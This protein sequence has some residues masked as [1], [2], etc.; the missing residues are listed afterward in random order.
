MTEGSPTAQTVLL[1]DELR[2]LRK[3]TGLTQAKV[4]KKIGTAAT[5]INKIECA[6]R[7]APE[8]LLRLML[9]LYGIKSEQQIEEYVYRAKQTRNPGWWAE[10][11]GAVPHWFERY[12]G[13]EAAAV[14]KQTYEPEHVP[15]LLQTRRYTEAIVVAMNSA[16]PSDSA[17]SLAEVR[18]TRQKRLTDPNPLALFAILN[19][20]VIHRHVGGPAVMAEQLAYLR[21]AAELPNV[22]VRILPYTAGAHPAMGRQFTMLQFNDSSIN[23]VYIEH[24]DGALYVDRPDD[25]RRYEATFRKLAGLSASEKETMRMIERME[26]EYRDG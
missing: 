22:T 4:A 11:K 13:L 6:R 10:H 21:Q 24:P 7:P 8:P 16:G 9:P 19:E 14:K 26:R 3:A 5:T 1:A 25:V 18:L 15:G 17:D 12:V 2:Q 23:T 20:A